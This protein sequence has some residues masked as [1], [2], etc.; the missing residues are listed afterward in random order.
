[1]PINENT[2]SDTQITPLGICEN[3]NSKTEDVSAKLDEMCS[4]TLK[5]RGR[6]GRP[7][8]SGRKHPERS[9]PKTFR[10]FSMLAK[11]LLALM[12]LG[13]VELMKLNEAEV[14][15]EALVR[16]ARGMSNQNPILAQYLA[17]ADR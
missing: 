10:N 1:M 17:K 8:G 5:R 11:Q 4:A 3:I 2:N 15:E 7:K 16:M 14:M 9:S 6:R 13:D 12:R